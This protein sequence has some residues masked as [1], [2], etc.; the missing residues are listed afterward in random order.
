MTQVGVTTTVTT[1]R[2]NTEVNGSVAS[3]FPTVQHCTSAADAR[4]NIIVRGFGSTDQNDV[5]MA[6]PIFYPVERLC[7]VLQCE[8]MDT[9]TLDSV[10]SQYG[11]V[12][13]FC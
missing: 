10:E 5:G 11:P 12:A 7:P 2:L 1:S 6:R 9:V 8:K 3:E 13:C 4:K